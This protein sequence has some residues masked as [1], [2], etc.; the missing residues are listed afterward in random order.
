MFIGLIV[1]LVL[2]ALCALLGGIYSYI[3]YTRINPGRSRKLGYGG[4][5]GGADGL[6]TGSGGEEAGGG[7]GGSG[8]A[9]THLFLFRK[10]NN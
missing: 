4:P 3:Y 10:P 6:A 5:L 9:G 7:S 2:M 1:L 8:G